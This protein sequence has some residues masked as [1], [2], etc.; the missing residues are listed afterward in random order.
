[1]MDVS[2]VIDATLALGG[3]VG[4]LVTA[5]CMLLSQSTTVSTSSGKPSATDA[6]L[7][8]QIPLPEA[9]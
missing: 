2:S 7:H 1:M 4:T 6:K 9:A 8:Q 3:A 5:V